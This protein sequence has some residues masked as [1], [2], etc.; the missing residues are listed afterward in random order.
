MIN[1][2]GDGGASGSDVGWCGGDGDAGQGD[3]ARGGHIVVV[4]VVVV[5]VCG[6]ISSCVVVGV[7]WV[8]VRC[9]CCMEYDI[10]WNTT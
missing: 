2:G 10:V 3:G 6:A 4:S 9:V 7:A 8:L 5:S 1:Y